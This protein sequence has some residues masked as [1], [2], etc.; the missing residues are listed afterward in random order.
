MSGI[1]A[2][3]AQRSPHPP[4]WCEEEEVNVLSRR[5]NNLLI[6][7]SDCNLSSPFVVAQRI[8]VLDAT[9][10]AHLYTHVSRR[11]LSGVCIVRNIY[12]MRTHTIV[13]TPRRNKILFMTERRLSIYNKFIIAYYMPNVFV[14]FF[15]LCECVTH[16]K[17][18][19]L[20]SHMKHI[21]QY[22]LLQFPLHAFLDRIC[23]YV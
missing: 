19:L 6:P 15:G 4:D 23:N 7:Y 9:N 8:C 10:I 18:T 14:F 13:H 17:W 11:A 2:H 16:T 12:S 5:N 3:S 21:T 20:A 22:I 1:T